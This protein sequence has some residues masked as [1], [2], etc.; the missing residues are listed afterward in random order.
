[1]IVRSDIL[2]ATRDLFVAALAAS[3]VAPSVAPVVVYSP[4]GLPAGEPPW[5]F[6]TLR[7]EALG[8]DGA[9]SS[10]RLTASVTSPTSGVRVWS[11]VSVAVRAYAPD[12]SGLWRD[13]M[14]YARSSAGGV[15]LARAGL[16]IRDYGT[17]I[18]VRDE[19]DAAGARLRGDW[20]LIL[21]G[22]PARYD[23]GAARL[24]RVSVEIDDD[25][26]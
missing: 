4:Q 16:A 5:P 7:E 14:G 6:V 24:S 13:V 9:A 21:S 12:P 3:A 26:N 1:M 22:A 15:Y 11:R 19:L 17:P 10:E 25:G 2:I 8:P 23:Y 18:I 20:T